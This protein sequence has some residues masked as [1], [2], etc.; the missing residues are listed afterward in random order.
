MR[1]ESLELKNYRQLAD[2][3]YRF[4]GNLIGIMGR[5]GSGKSHLIEALPFLLTGDGH[6]ARMLRWG[7][8]T[9]HARLKFSH[10]QREYDV[11][12]D[13]ES[14]KAELRISGP[15]MDKP[16]K[17]TGSTAVT[18]SLAKELGIDKD[19]AQQSMFARQAEIDAVLFTDPKVRELAMQRLCG[20]GES[21][22]THKAL[23]ELIARIPVADGLDQDIARTETLLGEA[24]EALSS[25]KWRLGTLRDARDHIALGSME[26][27]NR[28]AERKRQVELYLD[29]SRQ[30]AVAEAEI[31]KWQAELDRVPQVSTVEKS[32]VE[33]RIRSYEAALVDLRHEQEWKRRMAEVDAALRA[34]PPAPSMEQLKSLQDAIS[35]AA[36]AMGKATAGKEMYGSLM[37]AVS[38]LQGAQVCPLCGSYITDIDRLK[39]DVAAHMEAVNE[40]YMSG[41]RAREEAEPMLRRLSEAR[42]ASEVGRARLESSRE[43]FQQDLA[44][45]SY[46]EAK[47]EGSV[48]EAERALAAERTKLSAIVDAAAR[49]ARAR[50]ALA[51]LQSSRVSLASDLA[52]LLAGTDQEVVELARGMEF[53]DRTAQARR[54]A[55]V[56]VARSEGAIA[57]MERGIGGMEAG[58]V[59]LRTQRDLSGTHRDALKVL[60]N[61]RDWFHYSQGPHAVAVSFL[62]R[63][64]SGVNEFLGHFS[65]PFVVSPDEESLGFRVSFSDG[66]TMPPGGYADAAELSG[67]EKIMLAVSF[68]LANYRIFAAKLGLL[69]LDEPTVYLDDENV[70]NFCK[71]VEALKAVVQAMNLQ[72]VIATHERAVMPYFSSTINLNLEK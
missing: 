9:G 2:G 13:L 1:L 26:E 52:G 68:R 49:D 50:G 11:R 63:L 32:A 58:L 14:A 31:A 6:R 53:I 65:A 38:S 21:Q 47:C 71:V 67:G 23:G 34:I 35:Q 70:G 29:K 8:L 59:R 7:A 3:T 41:K 36:A 28:L 22:K 30:L 55:D 37:A 72:V 18:E 66:R 16:I 33:G 44:G 40:A 61:V 24:G 62:K 60:G 45:L 4:D 64:T 20:V 5:N 10:M 46:T 43:K 39:R 57:E 17:V 56:D 12:R 25:E 19:I 27:R 48:Q 51:G 15:D 69:S 42:T 54:Q